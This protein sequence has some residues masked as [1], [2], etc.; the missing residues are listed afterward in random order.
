[1][2]S[3]A[4]A[5]RSDGR[6]ADDRTTGDPA[7]GPRRYARE[8]LVTLAVAALFSFLLIAQER[9]FLR[10]LG[11]NGQVPTLVWQL[12][13]PLGSI[14][15][16]FLF[17][18]R[19]RIAL[20][21]A[22]GALWSIVAIGDAAYFRFF[23]SVTSLVSAGS[24][25]QLVDVRQSVL[26]VLH[27]SDA[28]YLVVFVAMAL[29]ALTPASALTG[30]EP[31]LAYATRKRFAC[32]A[33]G[34]FAVVGIVARYTPIYEKTHH[35]GRSDWV[36]PSEHWGSN[37]SFTTYATTFGLYNY[38]VHDLLESVLMG[39]PRTTLGAEN[40]RAIG[41]VLAEKGRLNA[42]P[43]PFEGIAR[44]RR[45]V[46]VQLEA[47]THWVVGLDVD[48][49]PVMPFLRSLTKRGLSWDY[50]MDV[51][52]IG[53]T[54][55]AE[56]A[57]MT[58]L[59]PDSS[60]PNSFTHSDRA[61]AYLPRALAALG[62]RTAS[63]HG[64]K[65][66]FWNRT[67]THP[68]YGFQEMYFDDVYDSDRILG[69]GVP[70]EVVYDFVI[71]RLAERTDPSFSFVISLTSHHPFVYTP[72]EYERLFPGLEPEHGWGLLGPYLRSARY[73]D[74]AL[75][76]FYAEMEARGLAKDTLFVFYGD[77]DMGFLGTEKTLPNMTKLVYTV[78]EERVPLVVVVPGE[79]ATMAAH[80]DG[81]TTATGG[82]H[83]LFP[84]VMHLLGE[85][86][87]RGVM[88][89]N[90]LVPD[91]LRDP[92]PLPERGTDLL[93]AYRHAI[94]SPRGSGPI[95]PSRSED[96]V[97]PPRIPTLVEG[98]RDQLIVRD[99][100]DHPDSWE[101]SGVDS[102]LVARRSPN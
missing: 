84:T 11:E 5:T 54:S 92:V 41:A 88:G 102:N 3:D 53:R 65:K 87:P 1:M 44:G 64:Y 66:S 40:Y 24:A 6:A 72:A 30:R 45:V 95:D 63:Y 61:H 55:D 35:I 13:C 90:L 69:L 18:I 34:A 26:D 25:H 23:G 77:H 27:G 58:G 31:A 60:R 7:A 67:Y 81:H 42:L 57:V 36:M 98:M 79:E 82:L 73:A 96:R 46:F 93:F 10:A 2:G 39:R 29:V 85:P 19:I 49:E 15:L 16:S 78:A 99:L 80:R 21:A 86:V 38:H 12:L 28:I 47:I 20:L 97:K 14:A 32:V 33:F 70:D 9:L 59:L 50:V 71:D 83:D 91:E 75:A 100:L 76:R 101:K 56:F 68:V 43:T 89:T 37:Y 52:S 94:Y 62:Y 74:D 17:P 4:D 51:T 22:I 8:L 48:G